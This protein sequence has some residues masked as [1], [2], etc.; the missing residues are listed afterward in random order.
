MAQT[1]ISASQAA[2][3]AGLLVDTN[4][5]G[6]VI[7]SFISEEASAEI[8]FGVAVAQGTADNGCKLPDTNTDFIRGI[9]VHHYAYEPGTQLG[10]TGIVAG[11]PVSVLRRGRIWV[12][13]ETASTPGERIYVRYTAGAGG[14]QLG[15][16]RDAAVG[17]ETIDATKQAEIR[18]TAAA[19]GLVQLDVDFIT[20]P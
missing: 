6:N 4:D 2:A 11:E 8:P 5:P 9:V 13:P 12:A 3:F 1:S 20:A 17:G 10:T 15:A 7:E 18:T 19:A 16:L 14:S